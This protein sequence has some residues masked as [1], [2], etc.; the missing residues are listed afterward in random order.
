LLF[1][2]NQTSGDG[3]ECGWGGLGSDYALVFPTKGDCAGYSA[4][5]EL[6]S[7][8]SF[9]AK[10]ILHE[11]LHSYGVKHVCR[12]TTDL[13]IGNPECPKV[14][15]ER[16]VSKR[17]TLDSTKTLYYGGSKAGID[18]ETLRIWNDNSG[19]WRPKLGRDLCWVGQV[20]EI[21]WVTF[22]E[23]GVVNLEIKIG[24]KWS[25]VNIARGTPSKC[26]GCAKYSYVNKYNFNVAGKFDYRIVKPATDRYGKYVGEIQTIRVLA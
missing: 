15:I 19:T 18:L 24:G 12:D 22:S 3:I 21:S 4:F 9:P 2:A 5:T 10:A 8:F 25:L 17:V 23:P 6:N 20:C 14:G 11:L 13:M 26:K 16:D 7:G 1:I